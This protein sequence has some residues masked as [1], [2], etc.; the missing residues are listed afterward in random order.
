MTAAGL[1]TLPRGR[2]GGSC[3]QIPL[4]KCYRCE[5]LPVDM[6]ALGL[7]ATRLTGPSFGHS[8]G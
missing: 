2:A 6:D 1:V 5:D 4:S 8:Q 3:E 7:G